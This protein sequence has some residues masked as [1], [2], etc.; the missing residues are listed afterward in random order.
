[1]VDKFGINIQ[2]GDHQTENDWAN[3]GALQTEP[4]NAADNS[5]AGHIGMTS[6]ENYDKLGNCSISINSLQFPI[7]CRIRKEEG[8][9]GGA[10]KNQRSGHITTNQPKFDDAKNGDGIGGHNW[11]GGKNCGQHCGDEDYVQGEKGIYKI[12]VEPIEN[13]H[14]CGQDEHTTAKGKTRQLF[15]IKFI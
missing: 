6:S 14:F 1:M 3:D 7:K 2:S 8:S 5:Q 11:D 12:G 10:S 9:N 13:G 4:I 15:G